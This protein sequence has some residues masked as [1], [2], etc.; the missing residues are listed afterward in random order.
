MNPTGGEVCLK[1]QK[2]QREDLVDLAN[3]VVAV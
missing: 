2:L 1:L 3:V